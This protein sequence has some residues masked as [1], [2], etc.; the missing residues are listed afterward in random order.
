MTKELNLQLD[1]LEKEIDFTYFELEDM[2]DSPERATTAQILS[3]RLGK[4]LAYINTLGNSF[5]ALYAKF[6]LPG[7]SKLLRALYW[8]IF[9]NLINSLQNFREAKHLPFLFFYSE[10]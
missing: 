2:S 5:E 6:G 4:P 10:K 9:R 1:D 8:L 7:P 3:Q